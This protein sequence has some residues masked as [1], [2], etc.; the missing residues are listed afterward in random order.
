MNNIQ[1]LR[2]KADITFWACMIMA[3]LVETNWVA[4]AFITMMILAGI[5]DIIL[6]RVLDRQEPE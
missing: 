5:G 4:W 1:L 2:I 3:N 6:K